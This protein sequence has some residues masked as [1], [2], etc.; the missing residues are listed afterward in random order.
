MTVPD[1]VS[2]A[3]CKASPAPNTYRG[4][5]TGGRDRGTGPSDEIVGSRDLETHAYPHG[6][7]FTSRADPPGGSP[8]R[9]GFTEGQDDHRPLLGSDLFGAGRLPNQQALAAGISGHGPRSGSEP[10]SGSRSL[11][12]LSTYP[13]VAPV[14]RRVFGP[15]PPSRG[16]ESL[17]LGTHLER[18]S[19]LEYE[20][21]GTTEAVCE[22]GSVLSR[23]QSPAAVVSLPT[24]PQTRSEMSSAP[25]HVSRR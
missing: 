15:L 16:Q 20:V 23:M 9:L 19:G 24:W 13:M 2:T 11:V 7:P 5:R 21:G 6:D 25:F 17:L 4:S 14:R 10:Q 8:V 12:S 1:F 3:G 22:D 18:L